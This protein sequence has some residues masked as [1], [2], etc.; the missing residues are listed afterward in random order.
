[1]AKRTVKPGI[2]LIRS[3][4]LFSAIS[5]QACAELA[6]AATLRQVAARTVLFTEDGKADNL[7][8]V[9]KGSA[10][11]FSERDERYC[12][13]AVACSMKPLALC[14][15]L[16]GHNTLSA[17]ALEACGLIVVPATLV[18]ELFGRDP[19]FARAV[20]DEL[21]S[22]CR[23]LV[24]D[25]K[26][27]RLRSTIERVAHWMLRGDRKS[28]DTGHIVIPFDKRVLASYLGMAPEHLSRSFSAL[29]S[30]GVEVHGRSV[31]L[32]DRAALS[33]A[34]GMDVPVPERFLPPP[35]KT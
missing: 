15:V 31:T 8:I 10:E 2:E 24:E 3:I 29:A 5:D 30:A 28:G 16:T 1:M 21:A 19:A 20:V 34:A 9:L 13:L 32:N 14:A 4:P 7:Y 12:T 27:H 6:A 23:E 33:E 18:I 35:K 17:R 25:F 22:E 11:L 26:N